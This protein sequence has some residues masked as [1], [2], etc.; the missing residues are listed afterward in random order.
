VAVRLPRPLVTSDHVSVRPRRLETPTALLSIDVETDYGTGRTD[1]LDALPRF[2]DAIGERRLPLTAFVEGQLFE[3]HPR[4]CALLVERGVDVQ[5]HVYDHAT[6]GD[7]A[8]SLR[9]GAEAY[10][11]FMGVRP[12]GY[13]AH[14]YHLTPALHDA[15]V[16]LG[17]KWDSSVMRAWGRGRNAHACF[18]HGDYFVFGSGLVE[19][20]VGPWRHL[21]LPFNHPYTLL[22]GSLGGRLLRSFSG[23]SSRLVPY[24]LHMTDLLRSPALFEAQYGRLFEWMQRWMW[25]GQGGETLGVLGVMCEDLRQRGFAFD[26]TSGLYRRLSGAAGAHPPA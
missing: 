13:R 26:T 7:T 22:A 9:R 16:S 14:T 25:V 2:L 15:L 1:A 5:L 8:E 24:N 18:R 17:F 19:F 11:A 3:R 4:L 6:P 21:P 20:P 23:P 10:A 12:E